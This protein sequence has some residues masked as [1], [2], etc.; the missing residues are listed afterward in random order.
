MHRALSWHAKY[1]GNLGKTTVLTNLV[2]HKGFDIEQLWEKG[3]LQLVEVVLLGW[4]FITGK[5]FDEVC[6]VERTSEADPSELI[7]H[8]ETRV[9]QLFSKVLR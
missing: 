6:H 9:S 4:N 2:A 1:I 8:Y 5:D 7:V 3:F